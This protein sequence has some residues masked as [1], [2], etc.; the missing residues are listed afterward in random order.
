MSL[1]LRHGVMQAGLGL[2]IGTPLAF[3]V[4]EA[5]RGVAVD[6]QVSLGSPMLMVGTGALLAVVCLA[7]SYLPARR[8]LNV[9]PA[10]ALRDQ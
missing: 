2:L 7:A 6:F 1:V 5:S 10:N 8:A 4:R 3:L 9:H